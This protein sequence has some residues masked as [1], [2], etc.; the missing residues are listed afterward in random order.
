M[1]LCVYEIH[2]KI[3]SLIYLMRLYINKI[4]VAFMQ[5]KNDSYANLSYFLLPLVSEG[6]VV[7][8]VYSLIF[9]DFGLTSRIVADWYAC[10]KQPEMVLGHL[11]FFPLKVLLCF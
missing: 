6:K 11:H 8:L 3:Y 7:C 1:E 5:K 9:S 10:V 4:Q 2:H